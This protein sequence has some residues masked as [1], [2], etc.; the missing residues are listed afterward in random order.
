VNVPAYPVQHPSLLD[1]DEDAALDEMFGNYI[2]RW[3]LTPDG[4]PIVT[5]TSRLMPVRWQDRAAMLKIAIDAEEELGNERMAWWDGQGVPL[6]LA[7]EGPAILLERAQ[8]KD[9]L[10]HLVQLGR[11]DEA[12]RVICEVVAKLHAPKY[13]PVPALVPLTQWFQELAPSAVIHG[14]ILR[15]SAATA[16]AL[17]S[18]PREIGVLHGDIH[19]DNI[20]YF[21]ERGWLAID[22]KGL[23]GERGFDYANLFCNPDRAIATDPGRFQRRIEVVAEAAGLDHKRLLQWVL[24]WAGLSAAWLLKG[25]IPPETPLQVATLAAAEL[26]RDNN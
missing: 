10:S 14:G 2:D 18:A 5:R 7:R 26:E 6:V 1:V 9:S 8:G 21:G 24:A 17:L 11:D 23:T 16:H 12:S 3:Q 4:A 19:H 22:P 25:R 20:L 15:V 13:R